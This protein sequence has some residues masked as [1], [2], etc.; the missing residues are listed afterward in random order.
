MKKVLRSF[1]LKGYLT[2]IQ[3]PSAGSIK[4]LSASMNT[5]GTVS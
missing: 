2:S 4:T 3:N 5:N 1:A